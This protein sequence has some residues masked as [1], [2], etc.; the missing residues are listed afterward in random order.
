MQYYM[1]KFYV[2]VNTTMNAVLLLIMPYK[3][4]DISPNRVH[5]LYNQMFLIYD[6]RCRIIAMR[7]FP[8]FKFF[9]VHIWWIAVEHL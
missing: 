6:A 4:Q 2:N 3:K 9:D 5:S 1:V 7:S 8:I